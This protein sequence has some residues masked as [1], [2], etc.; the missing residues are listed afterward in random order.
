[1]RNLDFLFKMRF[2]LLCHVISFG[3]LTSGSLYEHEF[4][5]IQT[6]S[7]RQS[8]TT[9]SVVTRS[10]M[11]CLKRCA[12]NLDKCC[13]AFQYVHQDNLCYMMSERNRIV[14]INKLSELYELT[15]TK[16]PINPGETVEYCEDMITGQCVSADALYDMMGA[17]YMSS[18]E[19]RR[20]C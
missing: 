3:I 17:D 15:R 20:R 11:E 9:Y 10:K 4:T 7:G 2:I 6:L 1:M 8:V 14:E 12:V 16:L 19:L 13:V 18:L 5:K